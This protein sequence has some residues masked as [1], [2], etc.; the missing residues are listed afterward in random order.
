MKRFSVAETALDLS[1]LTANPLQYQN[2]LHFPGNL[3]AVF[4]RDFADHAIIMQ[5]HFIAFGFVM[6]GLFAILDRFAM[7]RT[8]VTAWTLRA[9]AE[10]LTILL[11]WLSFQPWARDK[12]HW[13]LNLWTL[14]MNSA[15]LGMIAV[16]QESELA[17]TYYPI[18]LM[19][20]LIC[21]YVASGHLW[22][23]TLQ[24]WL[25]IL[26]Y[27]LVG[28]FDQRM[29]VGD[30][31]LMKF[32]TL[33][34]FLVGMNLVGMALGYVLERTNRLSFLQ[35]LLIE[36][37]HQETNRL[38]LNVLPA[39]VAERLKRGETVADHFD[40][41]GVLFADIQSFTPYSARKRPAEVVMTLNSIF[42]AFDGLAEKYA[43]EKIKTVGDAYMVVSGVPLETP[44]HLDALASM[45]LEMLTVMEQLRRGGQ[46]DFQLR[47]GLAAGPVVA[48]I[49]GLRKFSYDLWGDTVNVASR[50]ES[51]GVPGEIQA[52]REVYH[53]LKPK[54]VFQK[55]GLIDVKG[56]GEMDV[57]LLKRRREAKA[58]DTQKMGT[59]PLVES[60]SQD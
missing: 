8:H 47:I 26:G 45:A 27:L 35:R 52:T 25:A 39:S 55:R 17:F 14:L 1:G 49:I 16:A 37:Q 21:G 41:A 54:Y 44:H 5:R 20:V 43:L 3:E 42:S 57:Y 33:N 2:S 15:I 50:M 7:P 56:K 6:F 59:L 32:F 12:M 11:F 51:F 10:P 38:L 30:L 40:L 53:L 58:V 4:R 29:L 36:Q 31:S 46:C 18:G 28:V 19:L 22:Y 13:L 23:A 60:A 34:F 24:G 48:G 9:I